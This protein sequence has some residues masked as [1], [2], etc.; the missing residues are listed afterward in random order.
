MRGP[1]LKKKKKA[2]PDT[3]TWRRLCDPGILIIGSPAEVRS[4]VV[5]EVVRGRRVR[6][7]AAPRRHSEGWGTF[8]QGSR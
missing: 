8:A 5:D 3:L 2:C 4:R 7:C 6:V 1:I